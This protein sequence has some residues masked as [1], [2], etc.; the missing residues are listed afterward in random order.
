M[1]QMDRLKKNPA[2]SFSYSSPPSSCG[3]SEVT[4][5]T[6]LHFTTFNTGQENY[7]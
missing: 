2:F 7:S 4:L 5:L 1:C 3:S 6:Q